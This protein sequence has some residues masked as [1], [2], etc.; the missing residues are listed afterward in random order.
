MTLNLVATIVACLLLF[1]PTTCL[2]FTPTRTDPTTHNAMW[3]MWLFFNPEN[4]QEVHLHYLVND[5]RFTPCEYWEIGVYHFYN[6]IGH[7][8]SEDGG[9]HWTDHGPIMSLN[10]TAGSG[11]LG[12][13]SVIQTKKRTSTALPEYL[14]NFSEDNTPDIN[15]LKQQIFFAKSNDLY[16]WER[17][18][19]PMFSENNDSDSKYQNDAASRW[20]CMAFINGRGDEANSTFGYFSA[21][22]FPNATGAGFAVALDHTLLDWQPL[23]SPGPYSEPAAPRGE[24]GGVAWLGD[25]LLMVFQAGHSY[26]SNSPHGPFEAAEENFNMMTAEGGATFPRL[27]GQHYT[28]QED[29]VLLSHHWLASDANNVYAAPLKKVEADKNGVVR[30]VWYEPNYL[31][32]GQEIKECVGVCMESGVWIDGRGVGG[33]WIGLEG[34]NAGF[35]TK[36]NVRK[37]VFEMGYKEKPEDDWGDSK[38]ATD[39]GDCLADV[40]VDENEVEWRALIRATYTGTTLIEFYLNNILSSPFT[41]NGV[42][43]GEFVSVGAQLEEEEGGELPLRLFQLTL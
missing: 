27:W 15:S 16:N 5:T 2:V 41:V 34:E 10:M 7:A 25:E 12:S 21:D 39:R 28:H 30:A 42:V 29:L 43:T 18:D 37:Q 24:V 33:L 14:M 35:H 8:V 13:G 6:A 3:D 4:L 31:L 17:I 23:P 1:T 20:D 38:I 32:K 9:V 19:G 36:Y 40:D 22:P 26:R 11:F